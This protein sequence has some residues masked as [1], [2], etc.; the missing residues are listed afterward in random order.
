MKIYKI[1]EVNYGE[2]KTE[3]KITEKVKKYLDKEDYA[4]A[5]LLPNGWEWYEVELFENISDDKG[6]PEKKY[7]KNFE[8]IY[9]AIAEALE[10]FDW[11]NENSK[12]QQKWVSN[13]IKIKGKFIS[14][15]TTTINGTPKNRNKELEIRYSTYTKNK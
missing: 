15:T 8:V 2:F 12:H 9:Y 7:G 6:I 3:F 5:S 13:E 10:N 4:L 1:G 11:D 14:D